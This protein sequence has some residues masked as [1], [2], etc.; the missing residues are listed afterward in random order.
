LWSAVVSRVWQRFSPCS[1]GP[2]LLHSPSFDDHIKVFFPDT[3]G[4][5]LA[6]PHMTDEGIVW[7]VLLATVM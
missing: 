3:P 5:A 4:G 1:D 2:A 7:P 6:L